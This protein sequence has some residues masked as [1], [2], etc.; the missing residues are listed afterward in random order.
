MR[1]MVVVPEAGGHYADQAAMLV[2]EDLKGRLGAEVMLLASRAL[3]KRLPGDADP[4]ANGWDCV[5]L[6]AAELDAWERG[7]LLRRAF[8]KEK[9][10]KHHAGRWRATDALVLRVDHLQ[11][12]LA[13]PR[14][15]RPY[16]THGILFQPSLHYPALT[17]SPG[18]RALKL[19]NVRQRWTLGALLRRSD[20]GAV[21]SLDPFFSEWA[22]RHL[23]G[24]D[25]V[26]SLPDPLPRSLPEAEAVPSGDRVRFL[27]YGA[28]ARR[29]GVVR[30]VRALEVLDGE[31]RAR[32]EVAV[33]GEVQDADTGQA[34]TRL[35]RL[36]GDLAVDVELGRLPRTELERQILSADWLVAPYERFIGSSGVI[37]EGA[38]AGKPVLVDSFGLVGALVRRYGLGISVETGDAHA[39]AR[40][41]RTATE[42]KGPWD[43]RRHDFLEGRT[44]RDFV[45]ALVAGLATLGQGSSGVGAIG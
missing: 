17:G 39:F 14:A 34:L 28:L 44:A 10:V 6:S 5:S 9:I 8:A 16:R 21:F 3:L 7:P 2:R 19:R 30:L 27:L 37:V 25:R 36:G 41:L 38:A 15:T 35:Q 40:A 45:E 26:W 32:I 43:S 18:S 23:P 11:V 12:P 4:V 20:V 22:G 1:L 31:S 13:L 42:Q 24:G 33:R 29:K